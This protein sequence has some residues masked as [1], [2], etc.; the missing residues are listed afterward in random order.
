M[1]KRLLI[2]LAILNSAF[3]IFSSEVRAFPL[4]SK[5][6]NQS[7]ISAEFGSFTGLSFISDKMQLNV[8]YSFLGM[9]GYSIST[10][11][12][13]IE[14]SFNVFSLHTGL[15]GGLIFKPEIEDFT[16]F[17]YLRTPLKISY[18]NFYIIGIPMIGTSMFEYNILYNLNFT[19][20]IGYQFDLY[21]EVKVDDVNDDKKKTS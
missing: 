11:L 5:E 9:E 16:S 7:Y 1:H 15:G 10:D 3:Y 19:F 8:G 17:F 20:S 4:I 18:N 6:E 13:L 2:V 21:R 12:L 14:T